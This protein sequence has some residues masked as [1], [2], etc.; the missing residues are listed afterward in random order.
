MTSVVIGILKTIEKHRSRT[1]VSPYGL[2]AAPILSQLRAVFICVTSPGIEDPTSSPF[3]YS[4]LCC[5]PLWDFVVSYIH[6][7][8]AV[9]VASASRG[10]P[11]FHIFW[12][13][14]WGLEDLLWFLLKCSNISVILPFPCYS[15]Y[16]FCILWAREGCFWKAKYSP[17]PFLISEP[18]FL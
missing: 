14:L 12:D 13:F 16:L 18:S 2:P 9:H 1:V 15:L 5:V 17:R 8:S 6:T 3:F 11:F 10:K 4:V 7:G